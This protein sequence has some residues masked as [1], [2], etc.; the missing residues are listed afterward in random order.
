MQPLHS[1][2]RSLVPL[3][4]S[5]VLRAAIDR[6]LVDISRLFRSEH[7]PGSDDWARHYG[8]PAHRFF[9]SDAEVTELVFSGGLRHTLVYEP[10]WLSLLVVP[11]SL[12]DLAARHDETMLPAHTV[13]CVFRSPRSPVPAVPDRPVGGEVRQDG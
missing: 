13:H 12:S 3:R 11:E 5:D 9:A 8:L 10:E 4:R 7:P 2:E 1:D 6:K